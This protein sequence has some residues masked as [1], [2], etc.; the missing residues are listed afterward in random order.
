MV[1]TEVV[2]LDER[3]GQ[4]HQLN[5]TATVIWYA[6]DGS[7]SEVEIVRLLTRTFDVR[8]TTASADVADTLEQLLDLGL[9]CEPIGR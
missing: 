2:L 3:D 9:L 5:P 1:G 6:C 8:E 4:V 7:K